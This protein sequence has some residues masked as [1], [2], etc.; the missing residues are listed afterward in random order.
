[1]P[2]LMLGHPVVADVVRA[3]G[4][5]FGGV[6]VKRQELSHR[7]D[8]GVRWIRLLECSALIGKSADSPVASNVVIERAVFL[9]QDNQMFDVTQLGAA[10]C[11]GLNQFG[12]TTTLQT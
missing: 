3:R 5:R 9:S 6:Q 8:R 7:C 12:S 10:G 2:A 11:N 1:V 4:I